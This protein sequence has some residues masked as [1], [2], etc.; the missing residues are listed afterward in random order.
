M[1]T[2]V[3]MYF[4]DAHLTDLASAK[5]SGQQA[6]GEVNHLLGSGSPFASEWDFRSVATD[7]A[8]MFWV[9][10]RLQAKVED[11]KPR[12]TTHWRQG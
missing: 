11:L 9:R 10:S 3:S 6:F 5:G 2:M 7:H 4:D 8:V 1:C 12:A